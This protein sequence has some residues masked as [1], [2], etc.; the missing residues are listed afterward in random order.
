VLI[1]R[2]QL[3]PAVQ[4]GHL[5]GFS[6]ASTLHLIDLLNTLANSSGFCSKCPFVAPVHA[7]ENVP[8]SVPLQ[9]MSSP[10]LA[11][12]VSLMS[13]SSWQTFWSV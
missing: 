4:A 6:D 12:N 9:L 7:L 13:C 5:N 3:Q 1:L 10:C 2:E 8:G 11:V